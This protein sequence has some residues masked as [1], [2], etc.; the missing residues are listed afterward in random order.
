[1]VGVLIGATLIGVGFGRG[2]AEPTFEG[3]SLSEW[4]EL[5]VGIEPLPDEA[6]R[7]VRAIGTNA[8][9]ILIKMSAYEDSYLRS[10]ISLL[11]AAVPS[12]IDY[13]PTPYYVINDRG[14]YGLKALGPASLP[15]FAE[16]T[17]HFYSGHAFEAA[18]ILAEWG[19]VGLGPLLNAAKNGDSTQRKAA[20]NALSS[21]SYT[22]R[23]VISALRKLCQDSDEDV[24]I[25]ANQSLQSI[26]S[27]SHKRI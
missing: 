15:A 7:A 1:M 5:K 27:G 23:S 19:D 6:V 22:N 3:K 25:E 11:I 9:P 20:A 13:Y 26:E 8:I 17:N 12:L 16:V 10:K 18:Q 2:S 14:F 21:F 24:R 4:L